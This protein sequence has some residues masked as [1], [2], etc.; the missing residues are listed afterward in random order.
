M[1]AFTNAIQI[2]DVATLVANVSH[3]DL[4]ARQEA[5]ASA[6][7]VGTRA[8]P[9]LAE[10]YRTGDPAAIRAAS[11][12]LR[13]IVHHA[14][15]PDSFT[16]RSTAAAS[17]AELIKPSEPRQLRVDA[18]YLLGLI[19]GGSEV[20][21]IAA[22]LPDLVIREYARLALE[23]IPGSEAD[24]ALHKAWQVAGQDYRDNL[25]QSLRARA[26]RGRRRH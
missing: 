24:A 19:G 5:I 17:L 6:H 1:S 9:G 25:E 15:R 26:S 16:E 8:I 2:P 4:L 22:L 13:R 3:G 10:A 11:E 20:A 7:L 23:R 12:C 14:A 18:L 21:P